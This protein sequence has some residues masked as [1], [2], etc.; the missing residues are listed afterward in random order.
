VR[1]TSRIYVAG[2]DTLIGA[3]LRRRLHVAGFEN[4]IGESPDEPDLTDGRQVEDFFA[5]AQ[6]ELVFLTAGKSGGIEANRTQPAELMHH[7]LVVASHVIHA[8]GRF[9]ATK[10]LYLASSCCYPKAAPQPFQ[11][12][13]LMTGP[14]E[15]TSAPYATAKLAGIQLCRAYRRQFGCSFSTAIPANP[16]GPHDDFSQDSGH[17]LSALIRKFHEAKARGDREVVL[18]GTGQPRREFIYSR[19]LADACVFIMTHYDEP[20][21]INIGGGAEMSI[22]ELAR[23]IAEVIGYRGMLRFDS[24]RPDGMA[25]KVLDS[26]KLLDLGWRPKTNFRSALEETYSW[27]Q[28]HIVKEESHV[29]ATV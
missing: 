19:D 21:T 24:T 20:E 17:V 11:A 22:A 16:F 8:A 23:E 4:V 25:R 29:S 15:E 3:A 6:P 5:E 27:F 12:C 10:L 26:S 7:N 2:G 1:R 14:L 18:W 9:G 13:S 28:Q